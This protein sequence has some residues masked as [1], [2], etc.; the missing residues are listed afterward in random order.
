[1]LANSMLASQ[2]LHPA[3]WKLARLTYYKCSTGGEEFRTGSCTSGRCVT[4][5]CQVLRRTFQGYFRRQGAESDLMLRVVDTPPETPRPHSVHELCPDGVHVLVLV[6]RMDLTHNNTHL[7]EDVEVHTHTHT[8]T[9][10]HTWSFWWFCVFC[11]FRSS[12]VQSGVVTLCLF[13]PTLTTWRGRGLASQSTWHRPPIGW[14][15]WLKRWEEE[16]RSWTTAVIGQRS[17]DARWESSCSAS[18]PGTITELW[19]S[20][21][22][23][24]NL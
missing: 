18:Q 15:L 17:E 16:S 6:V 14:E 11:V 12:S 24:H 21:Q 10:K 20:G 5:D 13:S 4:T 3:W 8:H 19:Q 7:E 1:M 23:N 9:H 2:C 22:R